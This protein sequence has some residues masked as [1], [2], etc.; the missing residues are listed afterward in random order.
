M[1]CKHVPPRHLDR[2]CHATEH[3]GSYHP[4]PRSSSRSIH[5]GIES[6]AVRPTTGSYSFL[7]LPSSSLLHVSVSPHRKHHSPAPSSKSPCQPCSVVLSNLQA[8]KNVIV[9]PNDANTVK[10]L[11]SLYLHPGREGGGLFRELGYSTGIF[12]NP[13]HRIAFRSKTK[14]GRLTAWHPPPQRRNLGFTPAATPPCSSV[15]LRLI[16]RFVAVIRRCEIEN[17]S[18]TCATWNRVLNSP[19]LLCACTIRDCQ[20]CY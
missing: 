5:I 10:I 4:L 7:P 19:S 8:K 18:G 3:P 20:S 6:L 15:T 16:S 12:S 14:S 9:Q 2:L 1:R 17:G 13:Q 11:R